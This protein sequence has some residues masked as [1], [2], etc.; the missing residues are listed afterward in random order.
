MNVSKIEIVA[1]LE[2]LELDPTISPPE[3][4]H[5]LHTLSRHFLERVCSGDGRSYL[6]EQVVQCYSGLASDEVRTALRRIAEFN[7]T[8]LRRQLV[9]V[10]FER[11][12]T[13]VNEYLRDDT[14]KTRFSVAMETTSALL[15][16]LLQNGVAVSQATSTMQLLEAIKLVLISSENGALQRA[17]GAGAASDPALQ[18]ARLALLLLRCLGKSCDKAT[19]DL[20][21]DCLALFAVHAVV[22]LLCRRRC[23]PSEA[24]DTFLGPVSDQASARGGTPD[25]QRSM[26]L[27]DMCSAISYSLPDVGPGVRPPTLPNLVNAPSPY[28]LSPDHLP[29]RSLERLVRIFGPLT[30]QSAVRNPWELLDHADPSATQAAV[31]RKAAVSADTFCPPPTQLVN[32]GPVDLAAFRAHVIATVP[33]VTAL[34]AV[35]AASASSTHSGGSNHGTHRFEKGRQTNFDFETPCTTLSVSARDHRRTLNVTR[36]VSSR[37]DSAAMASAQA[38]A[39]LAASKKASN[40]AAAQSASPNGAA[41]A[42][43]TPA[44]ATPASRGMKRRSSQQQQGTASGAEI[45][46]LDSDDE[47][48]S[49][50]AAKTGPKAKKARTSAGSAA[51]GGATTNV[52]GQTAAKTTAARAPAKTARKRK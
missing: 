21:R 5:A 33:A 30:P 37:L 43:G 39:S 27:F 24:A 2:R 8:V 29:D 4:Y 40:G 35:S 1:C 9:S 3:R 34:D 41:P 51:G 13:A 32:L 38:A 7:L 17:E 12:A 44:K 42:G 46:V 15:D 18:A 50:S 45:V 23:L 11:L 31:A 26:V 48:G 10:A 6:G 25:L 47:A 52:T 49:S 36:L 20:L 14:E 16:K 22:R 28:A 19:T